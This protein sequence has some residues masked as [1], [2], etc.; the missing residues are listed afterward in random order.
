MADWIRS[1]ARLS[2]AGGGP[3]YSS[4]MTGALWVWEAHSKRQ[5]IL[6]DLRDDSRR[7]SIAGSPKLRPKSSATIAS[8]RSPASSTRT[9]AYN[10]SSVFSAGA[11]LSSNPHITSWV[12]GVMSTFATPA[13]SPAQAGDAARITR[14]AAFHRNIT[15]PPEAG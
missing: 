1:M 9:R 10:G 15:G 4:L 6:L 13:R 12:A 8:R 5:E 3:L 14:I 11:S 7:R 2:Q